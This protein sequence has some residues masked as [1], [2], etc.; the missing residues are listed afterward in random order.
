VH[1]CFVVGHR[2]AVLPSEAT[3]DPLNHGESCMVTAFPN[4]HFF[5]PSVC[6]VL[7][8]AVSPA[9]VS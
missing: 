4:S 5:S 9:A 6:S 2:C 8:I 1:H 3:I 7:H